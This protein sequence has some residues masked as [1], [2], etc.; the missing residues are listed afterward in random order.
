[1]RVSVLKPS[2]RKLAHGA[3]VLLL[4]GM[5]AGC[6]SQVSRFGGGVDDV[7]TASTSNQ[8]Q[9][10]RHE[11]QPFPGDQVAAAPVDGTYTGSTSRN[12]VKPV[13]LSSQKVARTELAPVAAAPIAEQPKPKIKPVE[14]A[15]APKL[16]STVTGTVKQPPQMALAE[17]AGWSR[18]G[19]GGPGR[20]A[21]GPTPSRPC[22]GRRR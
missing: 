13:D 8:R 15:A 18:A 12:A 14:V 3:A 5:A 1:M 6:S 2:E 22:R 9:I 21:A 4:A 20:S 16:D 19:C 11:N 10:L 7:F 17:P